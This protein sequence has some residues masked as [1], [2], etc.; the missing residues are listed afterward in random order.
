MI[1]QFYFKQFNLALVLSFHVYTLLNL[2]TILFQ[3]ISV[4]T[5]FEYQ[6][7]LFNP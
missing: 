7:V 3:A 5:L 2:K 1:K 4:S 6:T